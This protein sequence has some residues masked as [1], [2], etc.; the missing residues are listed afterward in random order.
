[1][2]RK[3]FIYLPVLILIGLA[4][5]FIF[6]TSPSV[7]YWVDDFCV[8]AQLKKLGYFGSQLF[9][10]KNWTG[11]YSFIAVVNAFEKLGPWS[12]QITPVLI[13]FLLVIA[14]I[15]IFGLLMSST[16][17]VLTIVNS[18]NITQ[19]F[20]WQMGAIN[21][22]AAFMFLNSI[23]SCIF[24]ARAK[25]YYFLVFVLALLAGGFS[26]AYAA[27]QIIFLTFILL[28]LKFGGF[29]KQK[30]RVGIALSAILGATASLGIM[31]LSPGNVARAGVNGGT[32]NLMVLAKSTILATKWYIL[33]MLSVKP[34][35]YSFVIIFASVY[36]FGKRLAV[37][38]KSSI[39]IMTFSVL[40][41]I[42]TVMAAIFV[43]FYATGIILP[44]RALFVPVYFMLL[45]FLAFSF[46]LKA[47]LE[48]ILNKKNKKFFGLGIILVN[49]IFIVLLTTS[50]IPYWT[51]VKGEIQN[52]AVAMDAVKPLLLS[53]S[54]KSDISISNIKA[55]GELDNFTDNKGWVASCLAEY[56][57]IGKVNVKP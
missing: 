38:S 2:T 7:R 35:L 54:G 47:F 44:E 48:K 55:V 33:R 40:A 42:F 53:S 51:R 26:E 31:A 18:P 6:T 20:Y 28:A 14:L 41:G 1:M 21:Y 19:S 50:L 8:A 36:L 49:V 11:R 37:S 10:W 25:K 12:V 43:G 30:E 46:G 24:L 57:N 34:F 22:T 13:L 32:F 16:F 23:L 45:S 17:V 5:Y 29:G 52:Y 39:R 3:P 56:Y 9:W 4:I 15:P 27:S